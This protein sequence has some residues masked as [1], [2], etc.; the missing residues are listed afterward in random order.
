VRTLR[1]YNQIG[2]TGTRLGYSTQWDRN[3]VYGEPAGG[4]GIVAVQDHEPSIG[5]NP[6]L[7]GKPLLRINQ[8]EHKMD[9]DPPEFSAGNEGVPSYDSV[10]QSDSGLTL[11]AL[12]PYERSSGGDIAIPN[13]S[14]MT[15]LVYFFIY[16]AKPLSS[17]TLF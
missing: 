8:L 15:A 2:A 1:A 13:V 7:Y 16:S 14:P 12:P 9:Y 11:S 5:I 4:R 17:I 3:A 10:V 6:P